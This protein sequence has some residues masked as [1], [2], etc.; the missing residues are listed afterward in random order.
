MAY[1]KFQVKE[2]LS[3]EDVFDIFE[4]LGAEPEMH[5]GYITALTICHGGDSHKLYYFDNTQ[6]CRCFTHCGNFDIFELIQKVKDLDL[7]AAIYYVVNFFNLQYKLEEVDDSTIQEDWKI[8]RRWQELSAI[9]INHDKVTLPEI[10]KQ[11]LRYYPQ[12]RILNWEKE[13]IPKEV[14]DFMDIHFDPVNGA[15]LIPHTDENNRLI[16]IRERTLVQ[17]NEKYGKY[18]PWRNCGKTY[19]HPL[20]FNLYGYYQAKDNIKNMGVAIVVES[21]KATMQIINYLGLS[22]DIAVAVCGSNISKYQFQMLLDA[23]AKEICIA[24]DSDY[25]EVGD[26]DWRKC[27]ERLQKLHAKYSPYANISFMFDTEGNKLG[28]KQSPS[29]CG[30]EIF[31]ELWKNRIFL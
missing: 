2:A 8:M 1:D 15:I 27:V 22:N 11:I 25:K 21:E 31:M 23:G 20:A 17:E 24:F 28:Y 14:C 10:D 16:G 9:K 12:P 19:G 3:L 29:D 26:D 18:R 7:N 5:D 30:E 4:S 13:H 6:L